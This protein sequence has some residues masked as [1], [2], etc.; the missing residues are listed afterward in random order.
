M[1]A[2]LKSYLCSDHGST[3]SHESKSKEMITDRKYKSF[4]LTNQINR[5]E[6]HE[7]GEKD[8]MYHSFRA[9]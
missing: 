4:K 9:S 1:W 8:A 5:V 3:K 6:E 2:S 7:E